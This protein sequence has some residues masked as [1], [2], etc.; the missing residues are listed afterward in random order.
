MEGP[1]YKERN[2][3][4]QR[5]RKCFVDTWKKRKRPDYRNANV[6]DFDRRVIK[7][8]IEDFYLNKKVV[9]SCKKLLPV[10]KE[11]IDFKWKATT[12]RRILKEMGFRWKKCASRR[13]FLIERENIVNWRCRYLQTIRKLREEGKPILYL[14]ETWVDTNLTFRKCWQHKDVTGVLTTVNASN[15]LIVVHLGGINGFVEGCELI[16]KAGTA[17]GDYHGQMNSNNFEKWVVE[18]VIPNLSTPS[19]IVMDNAPYHGKQ[20]DKVPTKSAV[21]KEMLD[22]LRRHGVPCEENMRKFTLFSLIEQI[23]PKQ[24]VYQIDTIFANHGHTVVRLP[25]YMC[26][27][28]AIEL[29]WSSVK[30]YVRS[31]NTTGDMSLKRLQELVQEGLKSITKEDWTG[32]CK[33]VSDIENYYW[34]KEAIMEDVIDEFIINVGDADT[35]DDD[36]SDESDDDSHNDSNTE[37]EDEKFFYVASDD[38]DDDGDFSCDDEMEG[39]TELEDSDYQ[40]KCP[41]IDGNQACGPTLTSKANLELN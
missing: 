39:I 15:R 4:L 13:K 1:A 37:D 6:D 25:P 40:L 35:S 11:R 26:D 5:R 27:L 21:K 23:R 41:S 36:S 12:L 24:K 16:Y 2:E 8:I 20:L 14:D 7:D 34:E 28:S 32:Y 33:H 30:N 31:H 22:Y 9:P 17:T 19:V 38:E 3:R 18:K 29:A 10:L